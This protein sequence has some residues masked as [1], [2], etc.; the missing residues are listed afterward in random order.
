LKSVEERSLRDKIMSL[1]L[2]YFTLGHSSRF[3][4][5]YKFGI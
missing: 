2:C 5:I 3:V 4:E 1:I